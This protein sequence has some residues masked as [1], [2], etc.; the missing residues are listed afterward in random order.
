LA[1]TRGATLA[2]FPCTPLEFKLSR[3][4][5][6]ARIGDESK[7]PTHEA[8]ANRVDALMFIDIILQ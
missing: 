1:A 3:S 6:W 4:V 2:E 5:I 8:A 7:S